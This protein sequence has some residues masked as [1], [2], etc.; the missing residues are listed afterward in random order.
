MILI[1]DNTCSY[2]ARE[3]S[4]IWFIIVLVVITILNFRRGGIGD[5]LKKTLTK[6]DSMR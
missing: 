3:K 2:S 1:C 6:L 5:K 4:V